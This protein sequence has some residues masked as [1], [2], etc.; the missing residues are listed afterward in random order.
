MRIEVPVMR[1]DFALVYKRTRRGTEFRFVF[2]SL[3][4]IHHGPDGWRFASQ[5]M[6]RRLESYRRP[7]S[8]GVLMPGAGRK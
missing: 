1:G 7:I 6:I 5:R 2:P 4:H 8:V 3:F